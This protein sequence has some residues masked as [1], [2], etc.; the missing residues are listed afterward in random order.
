[1]NNIDFDMVNNMWTALCKNNSST[2]WHSTTNASKI[3][4]AHFDDFEKCM[5]QH[6]TKE[7][8]QFRCQLILHY[9]NIDNRVNVYSCDYPGM[10]PEFVCFMNLPKNGEDA[11]VPIPESL[12]PRRSNKIRIIKFIKSLDKKIH[13]GNNY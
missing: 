1:M 4:E 13:F 12:N 11:M 5:L 10:R 6:M 3:H 9:M 2:N 7:E 8:F